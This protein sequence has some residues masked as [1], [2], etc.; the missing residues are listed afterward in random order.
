MITSSGTQIDLKP[1][2]IDV[3]QVASSEWVLFPPTTVR[4]EAR[5]LSN[6]FSRWSTELAG[7]RVTQREIARWVQDIR[8]ANG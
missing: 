4:E 2:E 3:T 5:G 8:K 6:L 7:K 1:L